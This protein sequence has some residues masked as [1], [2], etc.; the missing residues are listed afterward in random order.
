LK[1]DK[2][3]LLNILYNSA[4]ISLTSLCYTFLGCPIICTAHVDPVCGS[5]GKT[6]PKE[7][8][9]YRTAFCGRKKIRK[10]HDGPCSE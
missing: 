4:S 10:V 1:Y 7:C 8:E 9:L 6:Y 5:D 2:T 3:L